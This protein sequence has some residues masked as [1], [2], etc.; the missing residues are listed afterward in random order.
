MRESMMLL[1]SDNRG[2]Y[3]PRDFVTEFDLSQFEGIKPGDAMICANPEHDYYWDAWQAI[4]DDAT[5]TQDGYTYHLHQDGDLW[6]ICPE[7][8]SNEEYADFFGEM[9]PAP[10]DAF[11]YEACGDCLMILAN[12][13]AS[14][15]DEKQ[16]RRSRE[17]LSILQSGYR[18]VAADGAEYGFCHDR[19]EVCDALPGDRYRIICSDR[20]ESC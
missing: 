20:V 8:M 17:G 13:D 4:L 15:M 9:K 2:T 10:D 3:I 18:I 5:L 11:E 7:L 19:C 12:D 1:L 14:G 6:A 16:E